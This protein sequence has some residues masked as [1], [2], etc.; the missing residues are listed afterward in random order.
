MNSRRKENQTSGN[1]IWG[2]KRL[3]LKQINF[4]NV[5]PWESDFTNYNFIFTEVITIRGIT[6]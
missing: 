5:S 3:K 4:R 1:W 2:A 6:L